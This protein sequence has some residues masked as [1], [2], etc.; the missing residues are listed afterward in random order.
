[1]LAGKPVIASRVGGLPEL[2]QHGA[3]GYLVPQR[4]LDVAT[5]YLAELLDHP[6]VRA[7]MG[8]LGR[9]R[10]RRQ[11]TNRRMVAEYGRL[12]RGE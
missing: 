12:Y 1:M 5:A 10:A 9:Q 6:E 8:R 3:N 2:V 11:F 7:G 4:Q